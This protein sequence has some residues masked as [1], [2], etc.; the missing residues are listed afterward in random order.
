MKRFSQFQWSLPTSVKSWLGLLFW[1]TGILVGIWISYRYL[2]PSFD[3]TPEPSK[4]IWLSDV[5]FYGS[6]FILFL[7]FAILEQTSDVIGLT[8]IM[9]ALTI[10]N[11]WDFYPQNWIR[12]LAGLLVVIGSAIIFV[13]LRIFL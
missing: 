11:L 1:L 2:D 4:S 13:N 8:F 12:V 3:V 7:G 10:G 6:I 5:T 9:L